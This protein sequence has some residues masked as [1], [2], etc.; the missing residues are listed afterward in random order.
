MVTTSSLWSHVLHELWNFGSLSNHREVEEILDTPNPLLWSHVIL[1]V[2]RETLTLIIITLMIFVNYSN[3]VFDTQFYTN[4]FFNLCNTFFLINLCKKYTFILTLYLY[5]S[6]NNYWINHVITISIQSILEYR[7]RRSGI[8]FDSSRKPVRRRNG[9]N[10]KEPFR[11][12]GL[13]GA[14]KIWRWKKRGGINFVGH[15]T[16]SCWGKSVGM[17]MEEK[18]RERHIEPGF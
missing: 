9:R 12:R 18:E 3:V 7:H 8:L 15:E 1:G 16:C 6:I 17:R 13:G 10:C 2:Q 11:N 14:L 4:Y 5:F